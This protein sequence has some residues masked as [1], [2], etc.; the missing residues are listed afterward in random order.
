MTRWHGDDDRDGVA[1][2]SG[3]DRARLLRI[4]EFP[5]KFSVGEGFPIG[6]LGQQLPNLSLEIGS[7]GR[8]GE[9]ERGSFAPQSILATVSQ[10]G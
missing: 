7:V 8:Q 5:G 10:P 3:A 1:A 4:P 9:V 2:V 6:N